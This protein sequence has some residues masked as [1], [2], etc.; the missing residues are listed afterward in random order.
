M[1]KVE[2]A[3]YDLSNGLASQMSQSLLGQRIDGIWHT[4]VLIYSY[5][6][7]YGGGIQKLPQGQFT[8]FNGL[9]P[10]QILQLGSTNIT[11]EIFEEYLS[12]LRSQFTAESYNLISNNCNN[13]SDT[14][15][16]F[17]LG[18]GIPSFIIDLPRIVFSTPGGFIL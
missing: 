17:L 1:F 8:T 10:S 7:F 3:V 12:S 15:V 2:L 9:R 16:R 13:F 6:Y 4:G 5:E 18:I 14:I 11:Q